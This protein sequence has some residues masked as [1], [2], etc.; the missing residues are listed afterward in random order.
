MQQLGSAHSYFCEFLVE[1]LLRWETVAL[2]ALARG[3]ARCCA[4]T[5]KSKLGSFVNHFLLSVSD[6]VVASISTLTKPSP[7]LKTTSTLP[8]SFCLQMQV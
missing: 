6:C 4:A 1:P 7:T 3:A 2:S 8:P 5:L